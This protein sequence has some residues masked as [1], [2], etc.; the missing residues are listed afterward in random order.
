MITTV[1]ILIGL[2]LTPVTG[3]MSL[4]AAGALIGG[5][6]GLAGGF[7]NSYAAGNSGWQVAG[8]TAVGGIAGAAGGAV[9]G[10]VLG[11]VATGSWAATTQSLRTAGVGFGSVVAAGG[12]GGMTA[13]AVG[14]GYQGYMATGSIGG[15]LQGIGK[16][17]LIGGVT[18]AALGGVAYGA[19]RG[20]SYL[21]GAISGMRTAVRGTP[22]TLEGLKSRIDIYGVRSANS[23]PASSANAGAALRSK[24]SALEDAQAGAARTRVLPD[25]RIRYYGPE[26]LAREAGPTRGAAPALEW[27]P[28]TE[29]V[30]MWWESYDHAGNVV[31]VHPKMINGQQVNAPHYPPTGKELGQ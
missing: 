26:K 27:D 16:G 29:R 24:L 5:T 23:T 10:A 13:G 20:V 14:G 2:A 1:P 18:G 6:V 31:R 7:S 11:K 22:S 19:V 30:R 15:T 3:G 4:M 17:A 21:G 25:G 12:A 8:D 9:G 28:G